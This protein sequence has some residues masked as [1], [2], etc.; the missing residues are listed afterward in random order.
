MVL[1]IQSLGKPSGRWDDTIEINVN[2]IV[3]TVYS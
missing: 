3:E 2:E 1:W